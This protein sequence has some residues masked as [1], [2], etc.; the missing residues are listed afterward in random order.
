MN[1]LQKQNIQGEECKLN[2]IYLIIKAKSDLKNAIGVDTSKFPKKVNSA[3]LK[4]DLDKL[5]INKPKNVPI[6]LSNLI[7]SR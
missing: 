2:L 7:K 4:S 1:I 3:N 6:N 5:D